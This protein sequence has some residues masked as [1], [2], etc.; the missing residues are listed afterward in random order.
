MTNPNHY[1]RWVIEPIVFIRANKIDAL[2]ANIIKY[3]MRYDAK[4]GLEDLDKAQ[5]YLS[6]L[7]EDF[8][9]DR[10]REGQISVAPSGDGLQSDLFTPA[11]CA[12]RRQL[13]SVHE[14]FSGGSKA[15]GQGIERLTP[16]RFGYYEHNPSSCEPHDDQAKT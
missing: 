6:W 3:I 15:S 5:Q 8:I 2:R 16:V 12:T 7:R 1:S 11:T 9:S 13:G 10:S 4:D 14:G